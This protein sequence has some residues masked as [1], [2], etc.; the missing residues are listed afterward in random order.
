V[1][2]DAGPPLGRSGAACLVRQPSV[3]V[4]ANGGDVSSIRLICWR[5]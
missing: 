5:L 2:R 3:S 4:E 1:G